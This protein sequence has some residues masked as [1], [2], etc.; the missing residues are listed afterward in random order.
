VE[1]VTRARV[2]LENQEALVD[3]DAAKAT[4]EA[5]IKAVAGAVGPLGQRYTATVKRAPGRA[6]ALPY[7][8]SKRALSVTA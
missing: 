3:Y 1:G 4:I 6:D 5:M 2:S 8:Q 7:A